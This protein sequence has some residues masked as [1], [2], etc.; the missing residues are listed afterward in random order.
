M[1]N[2][3]IYVCNADGCSTDTISGMMQ[4][5]EERGHPNAGWSEEVIED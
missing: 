3:V 5:Q 1:A 2:R 4:H